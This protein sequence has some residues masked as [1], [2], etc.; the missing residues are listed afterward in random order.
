MTGAEID[1]RQVVGT[2]YKSEET[3]PLS[4][5]KVESV[6]SVQ[7]SVVEFRARNQHLKTACTNVLLSLTQTL[8]QTPQELSVGDLVEADKA[9]AYMKDTGLEVDWLVKKLNEVKE[10][11]QEQ[12]G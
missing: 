10:K 4:N 1:V 7:D 8:C 2:A 12:S 11:K 3:N 9:L 5:V 6:S